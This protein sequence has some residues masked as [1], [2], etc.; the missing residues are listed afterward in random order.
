MKRENADR[1]KQGLVNQFGGGCQR[2]GYNR[3]LRALHFH[4]TDPSGKESWSGVSGKASLKEVAAHPERFLLLCATC[5]IEEHE[6]LDIARYTMATCLQCGVAFR[7]APHK[8]TNGRGRF[9]SRRCAGAH[10]KAEAIRPERVAERFWSKVD[11][12]GDCWLWTAG[13]NAKDGRGRIGIWQGNRWLPVL[14]HRVAWELTNG[15][16]PAGID[17]LQTCDSPRCVRP[18]H[19]RLGTRTEAMQEAS[20]R[21]HTTQGIRSASAKLTEEHVREIRARYA[22]GGISQ[23]RLGKEYGLSQATWVSCCAA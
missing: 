20:K 2:C 1:V 12:A 16:I 23:S 5:H 9:C 15:P 8:L 13:V 3:L 19:Y 17:L 6:A 21:G 11:Q 18:E 22:A 14:A 10:E 4:H 7:S